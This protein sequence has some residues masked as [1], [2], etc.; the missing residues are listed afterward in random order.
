MFKI[1]D[2]ETDFFAIE[3]GNWDKPNIIGL[4]AVSKEEAPIFIKNLTETGFID[5]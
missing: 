3:S 2:N 4:G 1:C 5:D